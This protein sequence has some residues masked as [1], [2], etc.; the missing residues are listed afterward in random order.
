MKQNVLILKPKCRELA[1]IFVNTT[2]FV[3]TDRQRKLGFHDR[4]GVVVTDKP[5]KLY[6]H[7]KTLKKKILFS[8]NKF[9][10]LRLMPAVL[11]AGFLKIEPKYLKSIEI[12]VNKLVVAVTDSKTHLLIT[13]KQLPLSPT[14]KTALV[15]TTKQLSLLSTNWNFTAIFWENRFFYNKLVCLGL[16]GGV[17]EEGFVKTETRMSEITT[18]IFLNKTVIFVTDVKT[19]SGF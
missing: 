10:C 11:E 6:F 3:V 13:T 8:S 14:N 1:K 15:V 18:G 5:N 19:R 16:I 9:V 7:S 4:A 12:F 2:V 17:S